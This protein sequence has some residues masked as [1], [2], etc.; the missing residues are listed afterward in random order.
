MEKIH[1]I[2]LPS[3]Y[4]LFLA[5]ITIACIALWVR[6]MEE[7]ITRLHLCI[8]WEENQRVQPREGALPEEQID[9]EMKDPD[10]STV[11]V[12]DPRSMGRDRL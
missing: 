7:N 5:F 2:R 8:R 11:I 10:S 6:K 1:F 3:T 9:S 12:A 4:L